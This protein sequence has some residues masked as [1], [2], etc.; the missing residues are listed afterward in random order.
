MM[1]LVLLHLCVF[2]ESN[3]VIYISAMLNL[4]NL[5]L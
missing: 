1:S 4:T 2:H 3:I 5:A